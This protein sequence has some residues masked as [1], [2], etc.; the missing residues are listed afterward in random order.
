M[1]FGGGC[2][3]VKKIVIFISLG[4]QKFLK[5]WKDGSADVVSIGK[6]ANDLLSLNIK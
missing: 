1:Q 2:N 3:L 6:K 5:D 4:L